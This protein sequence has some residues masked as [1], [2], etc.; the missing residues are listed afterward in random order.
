MKFWAS[1][2]AV[3]TAELKIFLSFLFCI[4]GKLLYP[5]RVASTAC[6]D[7]FGLF[8]L[9]ILRSFLFLW[10]SR[11]YFSGFVVPSIFVHLSYS[12]IYYLLF[13]SKK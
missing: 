1:L 8:L 6:C 5:K 12:L 13:L 3:V 11:P 9:C 7:V 2:W 10:A 4:F